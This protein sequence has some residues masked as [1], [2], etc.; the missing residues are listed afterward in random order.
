[1][2]GS[3]EQQATPP[4]RTPNCITEAQAAQLWCFFAQLNQ[5]RSTAP[6]GPF[7]QT[8][9]IGSQCC[10]WRWDD[11]NYGYCGIAGSP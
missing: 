10:G 7:Q 2:S 1:M 8:R 6:A 11:T 5:A 4:P 9:C 3:P